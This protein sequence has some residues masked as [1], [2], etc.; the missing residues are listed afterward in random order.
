MAT[1]VFTLTFAHIF[2]TGS[3]D[4]KLECN[5]ASEKALENVVYASWEGANKLH[6]CMCG[7]SWVEFQLTFY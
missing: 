6:A 4:G 3:Q 7:C 2:F 5:I 1:V